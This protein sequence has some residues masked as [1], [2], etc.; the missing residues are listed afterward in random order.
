MGKR[1]LTS[2][3][4][5]LIAALGCSPSSPLDRED[6]GHEGDTG[7]R[8]PASPAQCAS[9][10][11]MRATACGAPAPMGTAACGSL[12]GAGATDAQVACLGSSSCASLIDAFTRASLVCGIEPAGADAGPIDGGD[13]DAGSSGSCEI[14]D[15]R[16]P[17]DFTAF[18][19][20][21]L[22]G[23]PLPVTEHC[24]AGRPCENGWC[25]DTSKPGLQSTCS[26][27]S[28]CRTPARCEASLCCNPAGEVCTVDGDCC[29]AGGCADTTFGFRACR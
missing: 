11:E 5:V 10:C 22:S 8:A 6:G 13:Q 1:S 16:C 18:R 23:R 3:L 12:C 9:V 19:C 17:E 29:G 21:S 7:E 24:G 14:G 2:T 28:D 20:E 27:A 15:R 26:R 4:T 25:I